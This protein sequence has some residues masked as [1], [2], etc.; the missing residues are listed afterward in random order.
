METQTT[1]IVETI[2]GGETQQQDTTSGEGRGGQVQTRVSTL[3]AAVTQTTLVTQTLL[4]VS[5]TQAEQVTTVTLQTASEVAPISSQD[6]Q[7]SSQ[8]LQTTTIWWTPSASRLVQDG[9]TVTVSQGSFA[10]TPVTQNESTTIWWVPTTQSG[11]ST[12]TV[13]GYSRSNSGT[14]SN[15]NSNLRSTSTSSGS[16][17]GRATITTT[18]SRG[19]SIVWI[20]TTGS[21][22]SYQDPSASDVSD[23][24]SAS[25]TGTS[26]GSRSRGSN[27]PDRDLTW[28]KTL[29]ISGILS[30]SLF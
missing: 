16:D 6:S 22:F 26:G 24:S 10:V 15:S 2:Q 18:D 14:S 7:S 30:V 5:G 11:M 12:V 27:F 29:L 17:D 28:K 3:T 19:S 20:A 1:Q 4:Y 25:T 13:S 9:S 23:S 8:G 21:G